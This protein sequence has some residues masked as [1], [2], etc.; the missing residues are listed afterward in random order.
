DVLKSGYFRLSDTDLN[1]LRERFA[2]ESQHLLSVS[3]YRRGPAEASVGQWDV[4]QL[5]NVIAFVGAELRVDRW[6]RRA[7]QLTARVPNADPEISPSDDDESNS[8]ESTVESPTETRTEKRS[9][10]GAEP[11]D[12]P[13]PGSKRK[14]NPA[15][16]I[17]PASIA[18]SALVVERL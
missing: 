15:R 8:D 2:L 3:G 10:A 4:D 11:V 18:W 6:L 14:P 1:S 9:F 17:H 12:V 7:R 5:E 13:L 16:D